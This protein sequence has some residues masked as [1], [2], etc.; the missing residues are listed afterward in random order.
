MVQAF[1]EQRVYRAAENAVLAGFHE[2][3]ASFRREMVDMGLLVRYRGEYARPSAPAP[4]K[5]PG[6]PD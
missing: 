2:D 1:D 3:V 4:E 5:A 6:P